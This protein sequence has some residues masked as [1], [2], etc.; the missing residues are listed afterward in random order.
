MQ[1]T[2]PQLQPVSS[3]LVSI[4][5]LFGFTAAFNWSS[6]KLIPFHQSDLDLELIPKPRFSCL[7]Q[8]YI[9]RW[10]EEKAIAADLL[11][12]SNSWHFLLL[13]GLPR[14]E[15]HGPKDSEICPSSC[16]CD[17]QSADTQSTTLVCQNPRCFWH[18]LTVKLDGG[19]NSSVRNLCSQGGRGNFFYFGYSVVLPRDGRGKAGTT[20]P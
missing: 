6:V 17:E 9:W 8:S 3:F 15:I 10:W 13:K 12:R 2:Q 14:T 1:K 4:F 20:V 5:I 19:S 16:H 18:L 11:S 7:A